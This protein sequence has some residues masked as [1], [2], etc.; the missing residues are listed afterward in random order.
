MQAILYETNARNPLVIGT[1]ALVLGAITMLAA[2]IPARRVE[3]ISP[4]EALRAD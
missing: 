3:R 4:L 1:V 2:W